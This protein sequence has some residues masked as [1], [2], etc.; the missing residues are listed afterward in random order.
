[1]G[2]SCKAKDDKDPTMYL[3]GPRSYFRRNSYKGGLFM[4]TQY[5]IKALEEIFSL[6]E[7]VYL[8]ARHVIFYKMA[9]R[10]R[11]YILV[12]TCLTQ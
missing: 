7:A 9:Y 4:H 8:P 11:G 12:Q 10:K 6:R 3:D 5:G 2:N 1:M